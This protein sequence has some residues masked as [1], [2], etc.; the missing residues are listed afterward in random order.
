MK[1]TLENYQADITWLESIA[2]LPTQNF[3]LAT[4]DRQI[5]LIRVQNFLN[6]L[7]NPEKKLKFIHIAGT[8]GKGSTT[9]VLQDLMAD[10]GLQ[11]G[12]YTSPF[13]T[14]TIEK[15]KVNEKL[16]SPKILHQILEKKI[17]PALDKYVLKYKTET[18]SYF[19]IFLCI[20]LLYFA[21]EKCDWVILE[22]GLGGTHDATN[23]IKNPSVTAI[24][25]VG[26]DHTELLGNTKAEIA[27]DK[28][29]IIKRNSYFLTGEKTTPIKNLLFSIA[30]KRKAKIIE[31][32]NL[33]DQYDGGL[34]FQTEQQA[35]NLNLALNILQT[36]NIKPKQAQQVI[37]NFGMICRQEIM[38]TNPLVIVDGAHNNDKLGNLVDFIKTLKYKKLHLILGLA[39]DKDY[40]K[41]LQKILP[42]TNKLYLTRFLIIHRKTADLRKLAGDCKK[43]K[44][45]TPNIFHDPH[46]ALAEALKNAHKDDLII[47]AGSFF[48]AG[49]LR[50]HWISEQYIIENLKTK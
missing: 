38:Q 31:L 42:L 6:L 12:S 5:F 43:V 2:N 16:I 13:A 47:I 7:D 33:A 46:Q 32:E 40:K 28:A 3:M 41:A 44:L 17:K 24:T 21:Q 8:A 26:L 27:T 50:K 4:S 48:L 36:L 23:V 25:N 18:P 1:K 22:A 30:E 9:H 19:E 35:S 15:I 14:T 39:S 29:G 37:H 10:S 45:I 34:Y 20:A 11:I 49:E